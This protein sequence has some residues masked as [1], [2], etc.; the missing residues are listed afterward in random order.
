MINFVWMPSEW[1]EPDEEWLALPLIV[2]PE[3]L[4]MNEDDEVLV[5]Y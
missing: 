3:C 2:I 4:M 1:K 5:I